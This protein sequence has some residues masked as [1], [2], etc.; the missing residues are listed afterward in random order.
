M[1]EIALNVALDGPAGAGKSSVADLIA[2]RFGLVHLDTGA[3][4]RGIGLYLHE[5]QIPAENDS[6][7]QQALDQVSMHFD[8]GHLILN[9]KDVSEEIRTPQ[10]SSLA[11]QY[12]A[13]PPVRK[14][15][16]ALQQE[17]CLNGGYVVDGRDIC[18]VVL[19]DA[20]VKVY[21]QASPQARAQRRLKQ[22]EEKGIHQDYE[23]VLK[24]IEERDYRD[25]HRK[26]TPLAISRQAVVVDTSDMTLQQSVDAIADLVEQ[27]LQKGSA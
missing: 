25:M 18:D 11:S 8:H 27:A 17:I 26:E 5:H 10:A 23:T 9:G 1:K 14:K 4:Y 7:L 22:N 2:E 3:M 19:P 21:L 13:L 20:P 15:L 6:R 12:A 16:V 24:E